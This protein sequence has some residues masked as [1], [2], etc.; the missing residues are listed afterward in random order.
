MKR[1]RFVIP[2]LSFAAAIVLLQFVFYIGYVPTES[3]EPTIPA[4]SK[5]IGIR[6]IQDLSVG[7]IVVF[8][9]NGTNMVK[10]IAA[11]PGEEVQIQ[12]EKTIVPKDCYYVLGDNCINSFDSRY[13]KNPFIH[14]AEVI[15]VA[16][17]IFNDMKIKMIY[18]SQ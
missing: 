18:K 8:K 5:V 12:G 13:W 3:M 6:I 1:M 17:I 14:R 9:Y 11:G 2:M 15:A 10:R 16:K 7:D 4:G